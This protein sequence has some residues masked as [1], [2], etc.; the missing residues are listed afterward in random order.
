MVSRVSI[1][2][3][4]VLL[5]FDVIDL[6]AADVGASRASAAAAAAATAAEL[7]SGTVIP[8][9]APSPPPPAQRVPWEAAVHALASGALSRCFANAY[10]GDA[11]AAPGRVPGGLVAAS[12]S[13]LADGVGAAAVPQLTIQV[14]RVCCQLHGHCPAVCG[15]AW[16]AATGFPCRTHR[17]NAPCCSSAVGGSAPWVLLGWWALAFHAT[18][19]QLGRTQPLIYCQRRQH[20]R[21]PSSGKPSWWGAAGRVFCQVPQQGS[22]SGCLRSQS[23]RLYQRRRTASPGC[24]ISCG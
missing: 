4:C 1:R 8:D 11:V 12:A 21:S 9:A 7:P 16:A 17:L 14:R 3:G 19:R 20:R 15:N 6:S 22:G 24:T 10:V 13:A 23:R 2:A 5:S 18:A